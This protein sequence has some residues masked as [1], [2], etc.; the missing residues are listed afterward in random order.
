MISIDDLIN[1]PDFLT[2]ALYQPFAF[3]D[4]PGDIL[5]GPHSLFA[6]PVNHLGEFV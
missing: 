4:L 6:S 1:Q 5:Q 3:T 2:Q